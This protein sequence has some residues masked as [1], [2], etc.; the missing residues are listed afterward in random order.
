VMRYGAAGVMYDDTTP[1]ARKESILAARLLSKANDF[2]YL[3][4]Y[5]LS[6]ASELL[7][8]KTETLEKQDGTLRWHPYSAPLSDIAPLLFAH[9]EPKPMF[10]RPHPLFVTGEGPL[11]WPSVVSIDEL[12]NIHGCVWLLGLLA[13]WEHW[14]KKKLK[15]SSY[16]LHGKP[17][18]RHKLTLGQ[19]RRH[20]KSEGMENGKM[21][22]KALIEWRNEVVHNL[23]KSSFSIPA[24]ELVRKF[25]KTLHACSITASKQ[26][27]KRRMAASITREKFKE[28][29]FTKI[30]EREV[31]LLQFDHLFPEG[32]I[33]RMG[34]V[35]PSLRG[36]WFSPQTTFVSKQ[37]LKRH[38]ELGIDPRTP[39][40]VFFGKIRTE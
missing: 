16:D 29:E 14:G 5:P 9:A 15:K 18:P 12:N 1:Q 39:S 36:K 26:E 28:M 37:A 27:N 33:I 6:E 22:S 7:H 23:S 11:R 35:H 19:I 8:V 38:F 10:V 2:D 21:P 4:A 31:V 20:L 17:Q 13:K 25:L 3:V 34:D 24:Y 30:S 32:D 40:N